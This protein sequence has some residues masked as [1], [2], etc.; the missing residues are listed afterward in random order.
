MLASNIARYRLWLHDAC[1]L[2]SMGL[3][4][5]CGLIYEYLLAHYAGFVLG[6]VESTIYGMIGLMIVAMGL[7]AFSASR[8]QHSF[9]VFVWLELLIA[10][11]GGSAILLLAAI[12]AAVRLLP[13]V[14]A[15]NFGLPDDIQLN[16][17]LI[18]QL[19]RGLRLLPYVTG[20]VLGWLIGMEIPL[21]ARIRETLHQKHLS[22]NTGTLYGADYIGAGIGAA[23][24]VGLL[25]SL[26]ISRAAAI[27]AGG[28][29]LAGFGFLLI[30]RQRIA[31]WRWLAALHVLVLLMVG[32]IFSQGPSWMLQLESLLYR[33]PVVFSHSSRYQH[34]VLTER[35]LGA[36]PVISL[37]LNGRLQ[38]SSEDESLYHRLLVHPAMRV[39]AKTERVLVIGGG[40]G[41][42][43]REVWRFP[44]KQAVLVDLD[45]ELVGLFKNPGDEP[46]R[47]RLQ[48][49][50]QYALQDPRLDL[51]IN[52]AFIEIEQLARE[53]QRFDVIVVDLPDPGHPDLDKLYSTAFYRGLHRLLNADGALVVQSTSPYHARKAFLSIG[54]TLAA[55]GFQVD[56]YHSN[57][58]SFG[59][60]GF[61]LATPSLPAALARLQQQSAASWRDDWLSLELLLASFVFPADFFNGLD[62]IK[63]NHLGQ[64]VVYSYHHQAWQQ[65]Q[66]G[67]Y[68]WFF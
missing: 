23:I 66:G 61:S 53:R 57:I 27:T 48:Q 31:H 46:F 24:W 42:A 60:W 38:F 8:I 45:A 2:G 59:Q 62:Q 12:Q 6:S 26:D 47:S 16:G 65:Q 54:R 32:Q 9:Q 55:S 67:L 36:K 34:L 52:D 29:L 28:N 25:L 63:V 1:I 5:A 18:E 19:Q 41:L 7:G 20:F 10:V 44:V 21:L 4:A 37:Y 33:D 35:E 17:G 64:G 68:R 22:H 49:L 51:R 15:Q 14:L 58:P 3:L 43:L 39:A 50:N 56:A 30:Y 11:L 13:R 40:D